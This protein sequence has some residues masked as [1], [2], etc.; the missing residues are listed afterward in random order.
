[1]KKSLYLFLFDI[2]ISLCIFVNL[3]VFIATTYETYGWPVSGKATR[4]FKKV[5]DFFWRDHPF[6]WYT[7]PQ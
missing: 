5:Q 3:F 7:D 1:M 2:V 4:I 6:H